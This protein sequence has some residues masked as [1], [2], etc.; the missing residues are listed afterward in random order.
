MDKVDITG[1]HVLGLLPCPFYVLFWPC[2]KQHIEEGPNLKS[3]L[4]RLKVSGVGG[5]Q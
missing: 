2:A 1:N 5:Y 4:K 3:V